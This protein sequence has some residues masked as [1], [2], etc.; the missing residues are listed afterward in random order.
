MTTQ[1]TDWLRATRTVSGHKV[2]GLRRVTDGYVG[3]IHDFEWMTVSWDFTGRGT[4]G[5]TALDLSADSIP[6]APKARDVVVREWRTEDGGEIY[7]AETPYFR[8]APD[9][10]QSIATGRTHTFSVSEVADE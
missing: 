10:E 2:K 4:Y 3:E 7:W 8:R 1:K 9:D 5:R 6:S